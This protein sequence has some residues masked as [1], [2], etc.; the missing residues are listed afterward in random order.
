MLRSLRKTYK[1]YGKSKG[2]SNKNVY[3]NQV[4]VRKTF[5]KSLHSYEG[6]QLTGVNIPDELKGKTEL[7]LQLTKC[8]ARENV[9]LLK[10]L[11]ND[12]NQ[13][14]MN[15]V[16]FLK[17]DNYVF[18]LQARPTTDQPGNG[19]IDVQSKG[20][21]KLKMPA[22]TYGEE[23]NGMLK[24]KY[25]DKTQ[26]FAEHMMLLLEGKT[27]NDI[28]QVTYT[29]Y[30]LWLFEIARRLKKTKNPSEKQK[31]LDAIPIEFGIA[32]NLKLLKKKICTFD[33][34]FITGADFNPFAGRPDQREKAIHNI[35]EAI[36]KQ[37]K[38]VREKPGELRKELKET[39][40]S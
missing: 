33:D 24:A 18:K 20:K 1:T 25:G 32:R 22:L 23:L 8:K 40:G 19:Y 12:Q 26:K 3:K 10:R 27:N 11:V 29:I 38:K 5:W 30:I 39:Y 2:F 28:P 13:F 14:K 34:V 6:Y 31:A 37:E 4:N 17:I 9:Q 21:K 36:A 15:E 16:I 35:N 7:I